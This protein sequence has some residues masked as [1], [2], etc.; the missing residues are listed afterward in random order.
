MYRTVVSGS[1][2][3]VIQFG[4]NLELA[5][6]PDASLQ[7]DSKAG[8]GEI[9]IPLKTTERVPGCIRAPSKQILTQ[10]LAVDV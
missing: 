5:R 10:V 8:A 1:R 9:E 4:D 6:L 2:V 3:G 7:F